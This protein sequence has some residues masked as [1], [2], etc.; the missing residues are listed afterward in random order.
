MTKQEHKLK[1]MLNY[2]EVDLKGQ[3]NEKMEILTN[4]FNA[5]TKFI[6]NNI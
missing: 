2:F 6:G 5:I 1:S 4:D 3:K